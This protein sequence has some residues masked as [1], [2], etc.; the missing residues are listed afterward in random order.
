MKVRTVAAVGGALVG[1]A[2]SPAAAPAHVHPFNPAATCAPSETGAGN[3]AEA[4]FTAPGVQQHWDIVDLVPEA[5][6]TQFLIPLSN[7][8]NADE[9]SGAIAPPTLFTGNPGTA[10]ATDN[11]A[12]PKP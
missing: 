1:L 10:T 3:E 5:P 7:P 8:G 6:G 4:F 9:S 11:C 12:H 2:A